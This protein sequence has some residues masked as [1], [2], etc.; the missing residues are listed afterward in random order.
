[1]SKTLILSALLI[2]GVAFVNPV[3]GQPEGQHGELGRRFD[4]SPRLNFR[5][6]R[7]AQ[8]DPAG[9]ARPV[10]PADD[11]EGPVIMPVQPAPVRPVPAVPADQPEAPKPKEMIQKSIKIGLGVGAGVGVGMGVLGGAL[12]YS[13][14][15]AAGW[16][17]AAALTAGIGLGLGV[18]I[19]FVALGF[20]V[21]SMVGLLKVGE[22]LFPD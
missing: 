2:A 1:M 14:A 8:A 16:S 12:A 9:D 11:S 13:A 18:A 19:G 4:V 3:S 7:V 22:T 10:A 15:G 5:P 17:T 6:L 21:G 20:L